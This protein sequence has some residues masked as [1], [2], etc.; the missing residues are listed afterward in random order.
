M[1]QTDMSNLLLPANK[2]IKNLWDHLTT[3][4]EASM[5]LS[6]RKIL[7]CQF[8]QFMESS[9]LKNP[10]KITN[11]ITISHSVFIIQQY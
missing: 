2:K 8:H 4:E 6:R 3:F 9:I 10:I 5:V 11:W 1:P 7:K